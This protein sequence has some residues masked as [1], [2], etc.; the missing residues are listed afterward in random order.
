[1]I[2]GAAWT[3]DSCVDIVAGLGVKFWKTLRLANRFLTVVMCFRAWNFRKNSLEIKY[4]RTLVQLKFNFD[5]L[6]YS[7][8][9]ACG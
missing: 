3:V 7:S 1:M 8:V 2:H 5:S 6:I 4:L 9:W